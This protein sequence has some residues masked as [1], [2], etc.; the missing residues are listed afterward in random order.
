M[1]TNFRNF[2]LLFGQI[3]AHV[4]LFAAPFFLTGVDWLIVLLLYFVG[5]CLGGTITYHRLLSHKS[6]N[7]PAWWYYFGSI[8]GAWFLIGSP[9]AWSN[10]HIAHHRYVDT[11]KD[12][13]SPAQLGFFRVQWLSMMNT[14]SSFRFAVKNMNNFQVFL[15][16]K[17][18]LIHVCIFLSLLVFLG[19]KW[20]MILYLVP[21]AIIWNMASL[22]NT[23]NHTPFIG[24]RNFESKDSSRN[25]FLTGWLVWGEGWHNNHHMY[26]GK[27]NFG[28][29]RWWE[30]DIANLI[31]KLIERKK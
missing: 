17:Y 9:L 10:N 28:G 20:V 2:F 13:H 27:S 19:L 5:G 4:A 8:C 11:E 30:I 14:Y 23:L 29:V 24:Y 1:T 16:K 3:L 22:V 15:H 21:S 6:W 26:P 25:N 31:I 7:A 12:P 18:E